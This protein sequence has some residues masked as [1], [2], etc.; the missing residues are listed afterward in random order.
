[1]P[2]RDGLDRKSLQTQLENYKL[3]V[4]VNTDLEDES[5]F[6]KEELPKKLE[7][8]QSY[9]ND[10]DEWG[11][12]GDHTKSS[13]ALNNANLIIVN[14]SAVLKDILNQDT[15]SDNSNLQPDQS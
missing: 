14:I 8:A 10:L 15:S 2:G 6:A 11:K 9:L 1:M 5:L 12:L 13:D 7:L 4:D 3:I